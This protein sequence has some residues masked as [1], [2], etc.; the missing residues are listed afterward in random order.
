MILGTTGTVPG[1][2]SYALFG[3][4]YTGSDTACVIDGTFHVDSV[5]MDTSYTATIGVPTGSS[6]I[7]TTANLVA[8]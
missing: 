1:S 8:Q 5:T 7:A 4:S 6:L 3:T 2:T